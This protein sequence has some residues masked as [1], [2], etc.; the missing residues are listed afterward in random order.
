[1]IQLRVWSD[2]AG[3]LC[4]EAGEWDWRGKNYRIVEHYWHGRRPLAE[5]EQELTG[6]GMLEA[7]CNAFMAHQGWARRT[8]GAATLPER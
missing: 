7:A 6:E 2:T 3:T 1:M 4:I 5:N 8:E